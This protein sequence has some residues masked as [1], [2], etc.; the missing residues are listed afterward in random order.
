MW[1]SHPNLLFD[2]RNVLGINEYSMG[3]YNGKPYRD[4][5]QLRCKFITWVNGFMQLRR[6]GP[7]ID[8]FATHFYLGKE[9]KCHLDQWINSAVIKGVEK[10]DLDLSEL[11][12]SKLFQNF[13]IASENY[14]FPYWLLATQGRRATVR[15]L[16]LAS[17]NL[18]PH[19]CL[20]GLTSLIILELKDANIS[21]EQ[22]DNILSN[23][24][25][26]EEL[27]LHMCKDLVNLSIVGP[28]LKSLRIQDC[29][30]L[31][32]IEIRSINLVMVE[33]IGH[34]VRFSFKNVPQLADVFM[35][36]TGEERLVG[37]TYALTRLANDLPQLD[38]LNLLT[39]LA[40][41]MLKLPENIPTTTNLKKLVLTVY[42]FQ[43]EDNLQW[44]SFILKA[45][46]LL[47]KLQLNLFSPNYIKERKEIQRLLLECPH[48]HLEEVEING[49][50]GNQ[51]E[52]ELLKYVLDN[53][54]S[55]KELVIDPCQKVHR[56][57]NTWV[58][59][60]ESSWYK[61]RLENAREWLHKEVP[62]TIQLEFR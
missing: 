14:E 22:V 21:D 2:A 58:Y 5:H 31:E 40:M 3:H 39:I 57:C 34:S 24:S 26:L 18:R 1:M 60:C 32:K 29:F 53:V 13:S 11:F 41:K 33:Y 7:K 61:S 47:Q 16:R 27:N 4:M 48:K 43:D 55:L 35:N 56:G 51:H 52:I 44:I 45:F 46:P 42:P 19:C 6:Q 36:F 9:S 28:S 12:C 17:C 38:S 20:K 23:C 37:V 54:V 30:R 8:L 50:Y 49:F 59:Q 15:L 62:P 25:L 10:I